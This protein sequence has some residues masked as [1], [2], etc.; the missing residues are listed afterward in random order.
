MERYDFDLLIVLI[1]CK[2][3]RGR[4]NGSCRPDSCKRIR[5]RQ[6]KYKISS[7]RKFNFHLS[8]SIRQDI[9]VQQPAT[10]CVKKRIFSLVRFRKSNVLHRHAVLFPSCCLFVVFHDASHEWIMDDAINSVT[11][12]LHPIN[13]TENNHVKSQT[14]ACM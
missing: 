12:H 14:L 2:T 13:D 6:Q 10:A 1:L 5:I 4:Q 8:I 3:K 7:R 11:G 9:G